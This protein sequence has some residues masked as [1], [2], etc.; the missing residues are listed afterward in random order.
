[1]PHCYQL[2]DKW[3]LCQ[4]SPNFS[5][6]IYLSWPKQG[7]VLPMSDWMSE[8]CHSL[9][10]RQL[11]TTLALTQMVVGDVAHGEL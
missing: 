5:H 1:M 10:A 3:S 4:P 11:N 8:H 6:S 7:F 9:V 2:F